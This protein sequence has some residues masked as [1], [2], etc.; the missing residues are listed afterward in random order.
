[1]VSQGF[2]ISWDRQAAKCFRGIYFISE[3]AQKEKCGFTRTDILGKRYRSLAP[4]M[5]YPKSIPINRLSSVI[6]ANFAANGLK[7]GL[8]YLEA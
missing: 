3:L 2:E 5:H 1:M 8:R 6:I 4:G 7:H